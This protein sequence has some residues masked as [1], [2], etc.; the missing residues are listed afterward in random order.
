MKSYTSR[1]IRLR[2]RPIGIPDENDFEMV[3][4]PIG[5]PQDGQVLVR[6]IYISV[7]PYMR[8][9]MRDVK[10]YTPRSNW[11]KP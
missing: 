2:K 3:E 11:V 5:E 1:E 9:R 7:D 4:V 10:S 8:G 6:N